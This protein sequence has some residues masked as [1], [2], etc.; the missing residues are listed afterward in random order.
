MK[1]DTAKIA[2]E[3][4]VTAICREI[5]RIGYSRRILGQIFPEI[6]RVIV[7]EKNLALLSMA[8]IYINNSEDNKFKL[9]GYY[10]ILWTKLSITVNASDKIAIFEDKDAT[11]IRMHIPVI[12]P[13]REILG[14]LVLYTNAIPKD[15]SALEAIAWDMAIVI[16][17]KQNR[18]SQNLV[19]AAQGD[20][21][22]NDQYITKNFFELLK[23]AIGNFPGGICV[24]TEELSVAMTNKRFYE[25]LDIPEAMFPI[26]CD[27]VDILRFNAR[28]GEYG[29]GDAEEL[30]QE[31]ARHIKLFVDQAFDR[32]TASGSVLEVRTTPSPLGGCVLSY[33]DVT[34]RK[35]AERELVQHRDRLEEVVRERTTEI[36]LQANELKRLLN[37]ERKINEQQRQFVTMA[38]HEFRT[39]LTIIDG[40]AQRVLRRKSELTSEFVGEKVGQIRGA[41][42]RMVE[43]MESI[44]ATSRL[45]HG[46][47]DIKPESCS[48]IDLIKICVASQQEIAPDHCF[49]LDLEHL[50]SAIVADRSSVQHIF[51][52]LLSNAVKYSP[53]CPDISIIGWTEGNCVHVSIKDDGIGIDADDLPKM[54]QRYFRARSST[55]IPGTGIGLNLV[56]KILELHQGNISV[57]S[58]KGS[59]SVFTVTLPLDM[60]VL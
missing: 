12:G 39:P 16:D 24:L 33:I 28:R 20:K 26:G 3:P 34:A 14:T 37:Q 57:E 52:N 43:L 59:G 25:I 44:L 8:A 5:L 7:E 60:R 9:S 10:N 22:S 55:G 51:T 47:I 45:D 48:I 42:R 6:L 21:S 50:P 1:Q 2:R 40:A 38:S 58:K 11:L 53:G 29:P 15:L 4:W 19:S 56:R 41:V 13:S 30:A 18:K 31:R 27:F 36:E 17:A 46:V 23:T 35:T 32:D 54:F 49:H